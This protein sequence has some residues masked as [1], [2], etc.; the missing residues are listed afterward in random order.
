MYRS[1]YASYGPQPVYDS[2][3]G[4]YAP[5]Q[6]GYAPMYGGYAPVHG[7]MGFHN[8]AHGLGGMVGSTFGTAQSL[9]YDTANTVRGLGHRARPR[10]HQYYSGY[11]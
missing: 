9:V 8:T 6:G 4:G 10:H 11:Y 2:M 1:S 3:Y 5:M 7:G